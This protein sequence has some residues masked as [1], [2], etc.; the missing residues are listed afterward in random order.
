MPH[1]SVTLGVLLA[2]DQL[3]E[4][5][6]RALSPGIHDPFTAM[7]C[8][9]RLG[10]ALAH[11]AQRESPSPYRFDETGQLYLVVPPLTYAMLADAAFDP[12]RE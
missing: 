3:V 7:A 2:V 9:D 4:I 5:A 6:V 8:I 11:A 1:L 10:I 12:I